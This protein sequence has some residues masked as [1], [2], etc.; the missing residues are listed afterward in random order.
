[1]HGM[2]NRG[3]MVVDRRSM[4]FIDVFNHSQAILHA[5]R[6]V[7]LS[8]AVPTTPDKPHDPPTEFSGT[9]ILH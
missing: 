4:I 6:P 9:K 5:P 3:M 7:E 8:S 1:M 2:K